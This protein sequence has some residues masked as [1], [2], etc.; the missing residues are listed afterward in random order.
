M[1]QAARSHFDPR[2][3]NCITP[4]HPI[5]ISTAHGSC[6]RDIDG[7][8]YV[9]L[10]SGVGALALGY[11]ANQVVDAIRRQASLFVHSS[12]NTLPHGPYLQFAEALLDVIKPT[13]GDAKLFFVNSGAEAV[14]NAAKLARWHT[15]R[16]DFIAL[17]GAFHGRTF[18]ALSLTAS[19]VYRK[20]LGDL[21]FTV[22]RLPIPRSELPEVGEPSSTQEYLAEIERQILQPERIAGL[23]FEPVQG[24]GGVVPISVNFLEAAQQFCRRHGILLIADEIQTG[25][26]RTGSWT[27]CHLMGLNPDILLLGKAI[28]GGLPLSAVLARASIMDGLHPGAL[29]TTM[30]G[31]ALA[32][33]AGLA[34]LDTIKQENLLDRVRDIGQTVR[35][36]LSDLRDLAEN[37]DIR[38]IGAMCGIELIPHDH[39]AGK[40]FTASVI[41]AART[42]GALILKAGP[43]ANVIRLLPALNIS[44]S[45]LANGLD[46]L[47]NAIYSSTSGLRSR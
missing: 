43:H 18:L 1:T 8:E 25:F 10:S 22:H 35:H 9:D 27:T 11:T 36:N 34:V 45:E 33:A 15:G 24:E 14:E 6:I 17:E 31:N 32:C 40:E 46:A 23:F 20:G 30:G 42:N 39:A 13:L 44:D 5:E 38:T 4:L 19:D 28:G 37:V 16:T 12:F 41:A 47:K 26:G 7:R 29:G 21:G 3:P 2:I